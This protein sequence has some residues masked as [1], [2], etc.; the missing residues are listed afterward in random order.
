MK[1]IYTLKE[2]PLKIENFNGVSTFF[3]PITPNTYHPTPFNQYEALVFSWSDNDIKKIKA[4]F[5]QEYLDL[6]GYDLN[7]QIAC[8]IDQDL[9]K[10][11]EHREKA[12]HIFHILCKEL[13]KSR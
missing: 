1:F 6:M 3:Y 12:K 13:E 8:I 2:I 9:A 11:Q 7:K 5:I 4:K 10:L